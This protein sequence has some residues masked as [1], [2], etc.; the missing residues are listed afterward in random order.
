MF[1]KSLCIGYGTMLFGEDQMPSNP[2][3][4]YND[5]AE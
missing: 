5:W 2:I 4:T 3:N 1:D